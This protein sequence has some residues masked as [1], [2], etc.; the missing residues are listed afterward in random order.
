MSDIA[1]LRQG[2]GVRVMI[3]DK[4]VASALKEGLKERCDLHFVFKEG[5]VVYRFSECKKGHD[6]PEEPHISI[7][8]PANES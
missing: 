4:T 5:D 2:G 3:E 1:V 7:V 8:I 6:A